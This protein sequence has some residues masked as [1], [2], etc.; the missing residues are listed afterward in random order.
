MTPER[1]VTFRPRTILTCAGILIAVGVVLWVAWMSRQV[2]TWVL[3][4]LFLALALDPAVR[5]LQRRGMQRRGAAVAIVFL[6]AIGAIVGVAVLVIPTIVSQTRDFVDAVPGYVQDLTHGR[7]PLGFLETKYHI[8]D[9]VQELVDRRGSSVLSGGASTALSVTKGV[10]TVIAA[11]VTIAFLT[12][13]M[14]LEGPAWVER[15]YATMSDE[16]ERRWRAVGRDVYRTISGY[17]TGNLLIS[18]IAGTATTVV[19]L[20]L[21]VPYAVALGLLVA[22]LDLIPL[23][24]ATIAAIVVSLIGLTVSLSTAIILAVFFIVYQQLENHLLQPVVYG[25]TVQL[26]PLLIL[27]SVLIG[28]EVMGVIGALTAIPVAGTIQVLVVDALRH[29]RERREASHTAADSTGKRFENVPA[30]QLNR[31]GSSRV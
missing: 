12:L 5:A 2:L 8:V 7:G 26:S 24:G 15:A 22:V 6:G 30:S 31:G 21:G 28:A 13:F 19:L 17:I 23:A 4:A 16:N 20:I 25:R 11:I 3:I 1:V 29:R 14:L 27:I 10:V 18:V 9:R